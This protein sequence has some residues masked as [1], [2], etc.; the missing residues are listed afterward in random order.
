MTPPRPIRF[1]DPW[2][3][4]A[5]PTDLDRAAVLQLID[6]TTMTEPTASRPDR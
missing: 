3:P 4:N 6:S 5:R 2:R 1:D